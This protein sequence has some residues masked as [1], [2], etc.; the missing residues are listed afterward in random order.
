MQ[1]SAANARDDPPPSD[2]KP[3]ETKDLE[4]PFSLFRG[5]VESNVTCESCKACSSTVDP[6]EDVGL[7][8]GLSN[9][10]SAAAAATDRSSRNN[11]PTQALYDVQSAFARFIS[12]ESLERYKCEKCGNSNATKQSRLACIPPILTLHLKRFRYGSSNPMN[13]NA[14]SEVS[15]LLNNSGRSAKIEGRIKFDVLYV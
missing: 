10:A 11:S 2:Q 15:Q 7:E 12:A 3:H 13:R 14:R 1:K 8:V 5:M 6:I 4:Y 9:E